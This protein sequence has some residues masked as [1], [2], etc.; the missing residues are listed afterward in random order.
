MPLSPWAWVDPNIRDVIKTLNLIPFLRTEYCCAG[1]GKKA[2]WYKIEGSDGGRIVRRLDID[3]D[4]RQ[5]HH[6]ERG[7]YQ[8]YVTITYSDA[9]IRY[10]FSSKLSAIVDRTIVDG[11]APGEVRISY[12]IIAGDTKWMKSK[13]AEVLALAK[14]YTKT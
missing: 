7:L 4:K 1:Y 9:A 10:E 14:E 6:K 11:E 12:Y 5:L 8:G 2:S 3:T 13:W